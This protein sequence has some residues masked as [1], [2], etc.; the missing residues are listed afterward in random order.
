MLEK[1][2]N[3]QDTL[4]KRLR[5]HVNKKTACK[6]LNYEMLREGKDTVVGMPL[7]ISVIKEYHELIPQYLNNWDIL[8]VMRDHFTALENDREKK[9]A[10]EWIMYICL[11]GKFLRSDEFDTKL[12]REMGF[13]IKQSSF[14]EEDK[15]LCRYIRMRN[16][17][18][19]RNVP[20]ENA[21]FVFWHPF[22]NICAFHFLFQKNPALVMKQCN[23][24][25][26]LQ[27]VRPKEVTTSYFEV[28]A[29]DE[30]VILFIERMRSLGITQE[31][32]NHPL[33]QKMFTEMHMV[34]GAATIAME[35]VG[36]LNG[37]EKAF[38]EDIG[39]TIIELN[40]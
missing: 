25:A 38:R 23:V 22:I 40:E 16:S 13:E 32:A 36:V 29:D 28:A 18:K 11:K 14:N 12:V 35:I 8:R 15:E 6:S 1:I 24:D 27:L 5:N 3:I 26:I 10:Y 31:Y 30:C 4:K 9:Y 21:Q 37:I 34:T 20:P 17:D 19:L 7:K 2:K 39:P 33:F